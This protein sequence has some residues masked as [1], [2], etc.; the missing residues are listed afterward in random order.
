MCNDRPK[1][2]EFDFDNPTGKE[3]MVDS[4]RTNEPGLDKSNDYDEF[5]SIRCIIL[6][7]LSTKIKTSNDD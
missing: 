4:K 3:K 7:D 6:R 5:I 1:Q 2:P